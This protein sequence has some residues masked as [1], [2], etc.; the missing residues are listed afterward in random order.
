[1][2]LMPELP[3]GTVTFLFTDIE[4]STKLLNTLGDGFSEVVDRHHSIL[5]S[6]ITDQGGVVVGTEG[7][8][9]FAVFAN[10]PAAVRAAVAAQRALLG[11]KWPAGSEIRVRMGLLT[12]EGQR[13]GDN[14]AGLDVHR[15]AR[16]GAAAHG[17]QVVVA[18]STRG[19][20]EHALPDRRDAA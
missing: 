9:F 8:A 18:D 5:R 3:V 10:A 13:G 16:I 14:Y 20:V 7:D 19:L 4:G 17:G 6:S 15:A 2:S 12:G 1:M 11:E